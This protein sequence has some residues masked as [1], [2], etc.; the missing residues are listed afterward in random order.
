MRTNAAVVREPK[1]LT[2]EEIEIDPPKAGEILVRT[3]AAGVCHSDL[4]TYMGELRT[5]PPLVLGHEG[6][7]V[8][9]AVSEGVSSVKPGDRVLINWLPGCDICYMCR[10][11]QPNQVGS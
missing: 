5:Q 9:E 10:N 8:V 4:H 1:K 6:A 3:R 11:G 7:G 2:I